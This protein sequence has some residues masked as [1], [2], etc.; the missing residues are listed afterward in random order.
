MI[1]LQNI[2]PHQRQYLLTHLQEMIS[3]ERWEKFH[4]VLDM[5]TRYITVVLEDIFQ[6]HNA[7]AVVR[8]CELT[9]L[10]DLHVI[11]NRNEYNVNPDIV[12]GSHKWINIHRHNAESHNTL[13]CYQKLKDASYRIVATSP[14]KNDVL[15]SEL[16]LHEKTALVFGNEGFG[17]SE[18]AMQHADAFVRIP[19]WGFTE[20]YNI[21]VAAAI[22]L[23]ELIPKMHQQV[24]G[25]KLDAQ[26]KEILLIDHILKTIKMPGVVLDNF[27]KQY[28]KEFANPSNRM[29]P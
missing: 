2:S 29:V 20:S 18:T 21:S 26:E 10:L 3:P 14:H 25:W 8:T 28:E 24:T 16:S 15:I 1:K 27:Q 13:S 22:C 12:V 19:S 11:E 17:L 6:P 4:Q 7:S 5:R 9:G 23:Y